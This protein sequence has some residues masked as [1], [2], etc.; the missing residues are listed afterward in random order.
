MPVCSEVFVQHAPPAFSTT[1]GGGGWTTL[2]YLENMR[3]EINIE[4]QDGIT[5]LAQQ[6][7]LQIKT[8]ILG[9]SPKLTS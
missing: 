1:G 4:I 2:P 8:S 6:C 3:E 5:F 9:P 7:F